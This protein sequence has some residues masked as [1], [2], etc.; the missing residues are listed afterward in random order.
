MTTSLTSDHCPT[1]TCRALGEAGWHGADATEPPGASH[2][3]VHNCI[4]VRSD[5]QWTIA[6]GVPY[7]RNTPETVTPPQTV[8]SPSS[9]TFADQTVT[10]QSVITIQRCKQTNSVIRQDS[11]LCITQCRLAGCHRLVGLSI[12]SAGDI[13]RVCD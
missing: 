5:Q 12:R 11:T 8:T 2:R 7:N 10:V 13:G 3:T 9:T 1:W 4:Q 6:G